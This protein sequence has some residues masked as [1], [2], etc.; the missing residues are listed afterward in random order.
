MKKQ[1][2]PANG[3]EKADILAMEAALCEARAAAEANETPIGAVLSRNGEIIAAAHNCR[4]TKNDVTSHAELEVLRLAGEIKGDWR[5]SDCTLYVTLEP[6]PMCAG[7]ILASRVGRVVFG[8]KD[9]TM[10]AMGSVL[11]LPRFPL[12]S[13]PTVIGGVL[14]EECRTLLQEFFRAKRKKKE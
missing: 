2:Y 9:A 3:M 5:L 1:N 6:C 14:E 13:H 7:A 11:N 12:G 4:E 10:G 8:A